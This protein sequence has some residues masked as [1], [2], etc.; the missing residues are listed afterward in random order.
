MGLILGR[1]GIGYEG[2]WW[3]RSESGKERSK[4]SVIRGEKKEREPESR[5]EGK[6][7]I[8]ARALG[9]GRRRI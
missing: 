4:E 1:D 7:Q 9:E 5:E 6:G 2:V 8:K 3:G